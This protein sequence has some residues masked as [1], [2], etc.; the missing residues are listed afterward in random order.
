MFH[1]LSNRNQGEAWNVRASGYLSFIRS[2]DA[3][4]RVKRGHEREIKETYIEVTT[5]LHSS[6][7]TA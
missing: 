7:T 3:L 4:R 1:N 5:P 2:R 6:E